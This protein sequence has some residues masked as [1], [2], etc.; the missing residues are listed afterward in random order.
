MAG[1]AEGLKER[2]PVGCPA[3]GPALPG[4]SPSA[5]LPGG[6]GREGGGVQTHL[7][8]RTG[9]LRAHTVV[10]LGGGWENLQASEEG[11]NVPALR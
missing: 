7:P 1:D 5:L 8:T 6:E 4:N 11:D 9:A 2:E 3:A 10:E